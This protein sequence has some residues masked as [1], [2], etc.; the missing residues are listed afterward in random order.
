MK[1]AVLRFILRATSFLCLAFVLASGARAQQTPP[2]STQG[3]SA[4]ENPKESRGESSSH[5][6][7]NPPVAASAQTSKATLETSET[8]FSLLAAIN[9]CGYNQELASSDPIREQVRAEVAQSVA[10]SE[11]AQEAQRQLCQFYKDHQQ[12]DAAHD[13][14]EYVSLGLYLTGPPNFST[15]IRESDLPPDA[16]Y[17]LGAIPLLQSYYKEVGL[18]EIWL[19]HQVGYEELVERF[20]DPVSNLLLKTDLY[21]KLQLSGYL[22]R[23]FIIYVEPMAAPGE[24][25]ARNYGDDYFLVLSPAGNDLKL[26]AIRHTYLHYVLDPYAMKRGTSLKRLQPLLLSLSTAPM[27][28]SFKND[29]SLLVT[30]SLIR[31]I[32]ARTMAVARPPS[33]ATAGRDAKDARAAAGEIE[34]VQEKAVDDAAREGFILTPYFY[35]ALIAFEKDPA[36]VKD[37]YSEWI[38]NIDLS[39]EKKRAEQTEF[40]KQASPEL[41]HTPKPQQAQLLDLAEQRLANQDAPAAAK[42]AREAL[43]QKQEDPARALFILARAS[44]SSGDMQGALSYFQ[45]TID[46]AREP[47]M[48]AW[49]HIYLGRIMD[50]QEQREAALKQ[51]QAALAAGDA[52]P[53]TKTAAE[54]GIAQPYAPPA[55][56]PH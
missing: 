33:G 13:L 45:R 25:N 8:L 40:A 43:D 27:D 42:L 28:E 51:Y 32:E 9:A 38:Y 49:A 53:D 37:T 16:T 50:L 17:V 15:S 31:A 19:K 23:R 4:Q 54:H 11:G 26:D 48:V 56:R 2:A 1:E 6:A 36:G 18:H 34:A 24:V 10:A 3:N 12:A 21:L 55:A 22:G 41:L 29:I 46:I 35:S 7:A 5:R 30:E 52:T 44:A 14:A 20:H 47:R 39:R